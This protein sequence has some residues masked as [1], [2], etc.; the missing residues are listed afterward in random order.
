MTP[1]ECEAAV[2][3]A[4]L[5]AAVIARGFYEPRRAPHCDDA[6]I[7]LRIAKAIEKKGGWE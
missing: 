2:K 4:Y 6:E 5:E 1:E 3:R 7:P